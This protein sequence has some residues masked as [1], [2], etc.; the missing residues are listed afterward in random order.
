MDDTTRE[1][2]SEAVEERSGHGATLRPDLGL[3]LSGELPCISCRYDLSGISITGMCP[4]CG[5]PVR[6]TLLATVDPEAGTF[7][8]LTHPRLA[9]LGLVVWSSAAFAAVLIIWMVRFGDALNAWTPIGFRPTWLGVLVPVFVALSGVGSV[10]LWKPHRKLPVWP[11]VA[12]TVA[13]VLYGPLV[14]LMWRLHGVVDRTGSAPY[15]SSRS[16]DTDR[17]WLQ[18]MILV[19]LVVISLLQRPIIRVFADRSVLLRTGELSRQSLLAFA[20]AAALMLLG[21]FLRLG[22]IRWDDTGSFF[23]D[24][25]GLVFLAIGSVLV[26]VG[27]GCFVVDSVRLYPVLRSGPRTLL[28]VVERGFGR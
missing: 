22:A 28:D 11:S 4:E 26:T 14:W 23:L 17:L 13:T 2:I 1:G 8:P 25:I 3:V 16:V 5:T 7:E 27:L 19:V 10:V 9:A 18:V 24:V 6:A 21:V 20:M 12:A 15:V